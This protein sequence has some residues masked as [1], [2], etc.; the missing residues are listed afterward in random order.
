MKAK[1]L[2]QEI[3]DTMPDGFEK[4]VYTMNINEKGDDAARSRAHYW[5]RKL[6]LEQYSRG[7]DEVMRDAGFD[8]DA[9][10]HCGETFQRLRRSKIYCSTRCRVAAHR[11]R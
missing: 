1:Q 7:M 9:C 10:Q 3:L 6:V 8:P 11:K 5:R 2:A 4:L